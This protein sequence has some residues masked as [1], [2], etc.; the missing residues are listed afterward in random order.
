MQ[1]QPGDVEPTQLP[2]QPIMPASPQQQRPWQS[3]VAQS[4]PGVTGQNPASMSVQ[5]MPDYVAPAPLQ[6]KKSRKKLIIISSIVAVLVALLA[7]GWYVFA[8]VY[9][10]PETAVLDSIVKAM[11]ESSVHS[12]TVIK[13]DLSYGEGNQSFALKEI[14]VDTKGTRALSYDESASVTF[15]LGGKDYT[16]KAA[17][18][19]ADNGDLY[20]RV[21]S[22]KDTLVSALEQFG[23]P[24][25]ST[26][27]TD[28]LSSIEGKWVKITAA[29]IKEVNPEAGTAYTC[30]LDA[31]KKYSN[32]ATFKK[33]VET[34]YRTNQFLKTGTTVKNEAMLNGYEVS[35]DEKKFEEFGKSL[36][37]T[38][39]FKD[40]KKCQPSQESSV[41]T[42]SLDGVDMPSTT[43]QQLSNFS[44]SSTQDTKYTLWVNQFSHRLER[45]TTET[46]A[47]GP[48]GKKFTMTATSDLSYDAKKLTAPTS[49]MTIQ[50]FV[51]KVSTL[52][53][54]LQTDLESTSS[55]NPSSSSA[56]NRA[57]T[58]R[59]LTNAMTVSKKAEAYN[60]LTD[61]YPGSIADFAKQP[62][63]TLQDTSNVLYGQLPADEKEVGYKKCSNGAMVVYKNFVTNS[64]T[65][66]GLGAVK[67]GEVSE[68]C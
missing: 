52:Y 6:P 54:Q 23:A 68:F 20:F 64:Y 58:S 34:A 46:T 19:L 10:K 8:F 59:A 35:V 17:G 63:S 21:D 7:A 25:L 53:T 62:E 57:R 12:K 66:I 15:A 33:E 41:D 1:P 43:T 40:I 18:F 44:S 2:T 51:T 37:E 45:V 36:K 27:T 32:D 65:S 24:K 16:V 47:P 61:S 30:V 50:E 14:V 11:S 29:D 4:S 22:V 56:N 9:N 3:P 26:Q 42:T 48:N 67:S 49:D 60:A 28:I 5:P 55:A 39:A 13:S 31:F 38:Q